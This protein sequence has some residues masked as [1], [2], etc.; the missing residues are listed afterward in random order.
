MRWQSPHAWTLIPD[1]REFARSRAW[2]I[3]EPRKNLKGD[4]DI[5]SYR[6]GI[7]PGIRSAS[8]CS[9]NLSGSCEGDRGFHSAS[10]VRGHFSRSAFPCLR[11]SILDNIML[12]FIGRSVPQSPAQSRAHPLRPFPRARRHRIGAFNGR[13]HQLDNWRVAHRPGET[14]QFTR[15]LFPN[16]S[17]AGLATLLLN[18][19]EQSFRTCVSE[20]DL[21][22]R[23]ITKR[24]LGSRR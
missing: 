22:G 7:R 14:P 4:S 12:V 5:R 24:A 10:E 6:S 20:R 1:T 8:V 15:K 9:S 21:H 23:A 13:P 18:R 2:M 19:V 16:F 3:A 11:L 17:L